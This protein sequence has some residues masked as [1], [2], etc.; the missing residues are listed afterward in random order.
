VAGPIFEAIH[1]AIFSINLLLLA[2]KLY[3]LISTVPIPSL[4]SFLNVINQVVSPAAITIQNKHTS[5]Y[6]SIASFQKAETTATHY[7]IAVCISPNSFPLNFFILQSLLPNVRP[8]YLKFPKL[9]KF[10]TMYQLGHV[11]MV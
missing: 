3:R 6:T 2:I 11:F 8:K 5:V 10:Q 4:Q 1:Y 9:P 7:E